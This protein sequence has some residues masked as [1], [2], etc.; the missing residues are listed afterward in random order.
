VSFIKSRRTLFSGSGALPAGRVR[1]HV[2]DEDAR[3]HR[4]QL[5]HEQAEGQAA[6]QK[7]ERSTDQSIA[8]NAFIFS[9]RHT[10]N[11]YRVRELKWENISP[12]LTAMSINLSEQNS[13]NL[14]K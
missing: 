3:V 2:G 4:E 14:T 12:N 5:H 10:N 13:W 7:G 9:I 1:G 8:A 11:M 6:N